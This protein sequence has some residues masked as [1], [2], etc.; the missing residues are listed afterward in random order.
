MCF[1]RFVKMHAV[2]VHSLIVL[3]VTVLFEPT[4]SFCIL[5][6]SAVLHFRKFIHVCR[7]VAGEE[8]C[9]AAALVSK[10]QGA[11]KVFYSKESFF[12]SQRG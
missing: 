4:F 12:C 3:D 5:M 9:G 11:A 7:D 2:I 6:K 8:A 10:F 1:F